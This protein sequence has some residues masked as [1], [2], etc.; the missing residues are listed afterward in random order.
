GREQRGAARPERVRLVTPAQHSD[1][2]RL[3]S[4]AHRIAIDEAE[5][6]PQQLDVLWIPGQKRPAWSNFVSLCVR[7][8]IFGCVLFRL[9]RDRVHEDVFTDAIAEQL[10]HL[11]EVRSRA[12]TR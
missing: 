9:E 11:H 12:W 7:I 5:L 1:V 10:L 3:I 8:E 2:I 4:I 6:L